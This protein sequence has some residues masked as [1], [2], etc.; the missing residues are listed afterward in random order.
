[1]FLNKNI[2]YLRKNYNNGQSQ[3]QLAK[4]L[5]I[6]RAAIM[7]YESGRVEPN[8]ETL[9]KIATYYSIC[10]EGLVNI[11]LEEKDKYQMFTI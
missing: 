2:K 6:S 11:D 7:S 1:M 5:G 8:I 10:I 9:I 3:E 4:D